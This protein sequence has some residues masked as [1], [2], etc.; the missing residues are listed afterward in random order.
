MDAFTYFQTRNRYLTAFFVFLSVEPILS[1]FIT[2]LAK[3]GWWFGDYD[4]LVCGAHTLVAGHS[5]YSLAPVCQGLKPA[6]YV[7]AP[8]V[9][10]AVAP[11]MNALG[12]GGS[13]WLYAVLFVP[14]GSLLL[15]YAVL[16]AFPRLPIAARLMGLMAI[17][18]TPLATG[19]IGGLLHGL[20]VAAVLKLAKWRWLF[21]AAVLLA[22]AVKPAMLAALVVLL[23][24][25]RPIYRRLLTFVPAALAGLTIVVAIVM[26]AGPLAAEW[27]ATINAIVVHKQPGRGFLELVTAAG[28]SPDGWGVRAAFVAFAA[29][30]VA[31]GLVL[32][33]GGDLDGDERIL[34]GLGVAQLIN[35]RPFEYNFDLYL[36]YPA[37]ALVVMTAKA[38]SEKV[39]VWLSWAFFTAMAGKFLVS[40]IGIKLIQNVPGSFLILCGIY[41]TA[42]WL[43]VR[44]NLPQLR[45]WLSDRGAF[46]G[47]VRTAWLG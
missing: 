47:A 41:G 45:L 30:V 17:P 24:E 16:K 37:M 15:W 46:A 39:F 33:E 38:R 29:L 3:R 26:T 13:R 12:P 18:G 6:V 36:L 1:A 32:S 5:P 25:K 11:L 27:H 31:G 4:A 42:I 22:A 44:Q 21:I 14:A 28:L 9:G 35:P 19:N 10:E 7:Y 43:V 8:Q 40:A 23:Y 34:L 2:R 20:I